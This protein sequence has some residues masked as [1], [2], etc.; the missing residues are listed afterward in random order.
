M[1]SILSDRAFAEREGFDAQRLSWWRRRLGVADLTVSAGFV[2]I[3]PRAPGIANDTINTS[4]SGSS[5]AAWPAWPAWPACRRDRVGHACQAARCDRGSCFLSISPTTRLFVGF[6]GRLQLLSSRPALAPFGIEPQLGHK[7]RWAIIDR[8]VKV[9]F[10]ALDQ[11]RVPDD[12]FKSPVDLGDLQASLFGI[13]VKV[14]HSQVST[15]VP[16]VRQMQARSLAQLV[17][18]RSN[19]RLERRDSVLKADGE[20]HQVALPYWPHCSRHRVPPAVPPVGLAG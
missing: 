10:S 19:S 13:G 1:R 17:Q 9:G 20:S 5:A 3:Q 15:V 16:H 18:P 14:K 6:G 7:N 4:R 11:D 8:I 2:K 12:T